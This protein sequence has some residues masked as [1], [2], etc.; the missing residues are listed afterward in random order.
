MAA[1]IKSFIALGIV[2]MLAIAIIVT[3]LELSAK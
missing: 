3:I 2:L 1:K